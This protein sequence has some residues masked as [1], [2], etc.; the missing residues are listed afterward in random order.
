MVKK[1][2]SDNLEC[3]ILDELIAAG[4]DIYIENFYEDNVKESLSHTV[5]FR[6]NNEKFKKKINELFIYNVNQKSKCKGLS[7]PPPPLAG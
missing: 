6:K 5:T 2:I 1:T 3:L 7:I 4:A